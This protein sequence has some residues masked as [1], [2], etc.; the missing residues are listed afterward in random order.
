MSEPTDLDQIAA[1]EERITSALDRIAQ[2][3]AARKGAG[4]AGTGEDAVEM[5]E[6]LAALSAA[7]EETQAALAS[8]QA[9]HAEL[10]DRLRA[11]EAARKADADEAARELAMAR[12]ASAAPVSDGAAPDEAAIAAL[13]AEVERRQEVEDVLR[14][15]IQRL[16]KDRDSYREERIEV[17]EQLDD[18]Q[19]KFAQLEAISGPGGGGAAKELTRLRQSNRALRDTIE[20]MREGIGNDTVANSDLVTA[21][22]AAELESLRAE[23]AADAAEARAILA[24]I[25][26]VLDA[27]GADA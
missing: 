12:E 6:R 4:L 7:L 14:R 15:R 8:E 22:L 17:Q 10:S 25:R 24:E 18:V 26:P 27:G 5:A 16:R 2:G 1:L 3:M 13:E 11:V 23:R 21:S 20:E 19:G 9:T